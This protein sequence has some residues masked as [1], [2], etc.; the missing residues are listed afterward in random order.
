[1]TVT[2][3]Q[4]EMILNQKHRKGDPELYDLDTDPHESVNHFRDAEYSDVTKLMTNKL[5]EK[6]SK[7]GTHS[8]SQ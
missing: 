6:L 7:L 1:M 5:I 2:T 4:E 3:S 8:V